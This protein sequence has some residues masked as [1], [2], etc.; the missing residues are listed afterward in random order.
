MLTL[1]K[2]TDYALI[3]LA[4]LA[5]RPGRVGSAREIAERFNLPAA[6]LM[7]ILKSLHHAGLLASTRGAKGGY[8]LAGDPHQ[9]SLHQ[10]VVAV[11]GQV[12]LTDCSGIPEPA[13][14][15]PCDGGSSCRIGPGCPVQAPLHALHHK[16]V[17]FL[18]QV[19]LSDL[20][21][22]GHRIDV[23]L[24]TVGIG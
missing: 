23:P 3:A 10:L 20:I 1:S 9:W 12:H 7:N 6:L 21:L 18:G 15:G 24:E 8:A 5:E 19:R 22:P 11:D 17:A 14:E 4:H 13:A 16:L 2:K